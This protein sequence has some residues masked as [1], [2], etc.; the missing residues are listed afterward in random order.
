LH[1]FLHRNR[2]LEN[3]K[4]NNT[5]M[6]KGRSAKTKAA[7]DK[8]NNAGGT[9]KVSA[10]A[11]DSALEGAA[12]TSA[13]ANDWSIVRVLT[14]DGETLCKT[15]ECENVAVAVWEN[16]SEAGGD[17]EWPLCESCQEEHHGG[18]PKGFGATNAAGD[19]T[20]ETTTDD[21]D[22]EEEADNDN[23]TTENED[24]D[25]AEESPQQ[26]DANKTSKDDSDSEDQDKEISGGDEKE[27]NV[28]PDDDNDDDEEEDDEDEEDDEQWELKKILTK[29]NVT[30]DAP[31]KCSTEECML[32]ACCLYVSSTSG[33]KW[34]SCIDCQQVDY[35][36]WPPVEELPVASL[37]KDHV[38][39]LIDK[40]S[41]KKR[42]AM[43]PIIDESLSP[44]PSKNTQGTAETNTITPL[45]SAGTSTAQAK[46]SKATIT[47]T[48]AKPKQQSEAALK[49]HA[50]WQKAAI[51]AGGPDARIIVSKDKAKEVIFQLLYDRMMPMNITMIHTVSLS[52]IYL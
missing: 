48:P 14:N 13:A 39:A 23:S 29:A 44:M 3:N 36:G 28:E 37:A 50:E 45:G 42:P 38:Q 19:T 7:A 46:G 20:K 15:D 52:C 9:K 22:R 2:K 24:V 5:I 30:K 11:A 35:G 12:A 34:Y 17:D 31:I 43:P 33:E 25:A 8:N 26:Q 47:P 41:K 40:C 21:V 4:H 10:A 51:K 1:H 32:A 27:D 16:K 49:R 6:A 18:W